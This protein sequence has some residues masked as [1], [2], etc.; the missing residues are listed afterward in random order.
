MLD[1]PRLA[2]LVDAHVDTR[3]M[4]AEY[5]RLFGVRLEEVDDGRE[6]LAKAVAIRPDVIVADTRLPGINGYELCQH[7]RETAETC[8]IPIVIVTAEAFPC[9]L[10]HAD[11]AGADAV[12]V[13]PVAGNIARRNSTAR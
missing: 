10:S 4:Y 12:L 9:D 3:T 6:A 11:A 8:A 7:L 13:K 5:L 2:L 1:A